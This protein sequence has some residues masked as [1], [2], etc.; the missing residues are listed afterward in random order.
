L[1][2]RSSSDGVIK[3]DEPHQRN[4]SMGSV[5]TFWMRERRSS[6]FVVNSRNTCKSTLSTKLGHRV[7]SIRRVVKEGGRAIGSF[8]GAPLSF[9]IQYKS[10]RVDKFG[11]SSRMRQSRFFGAM[12]ESV[13]DLSSF[14]R[15][16]PL[17]C[18]R[19]KASVARE[20]SIG[21]WRTLA[22]FTNNARA[23]AAGA[24]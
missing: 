15:Q 1:G 16:T 7:P 12:C 10:S 19:I 6:W 18:K 2:I 17:R 20:L 24:F 11:S 23:S 21:F 4:D 13:R 5:S 9:D 8:I 14:I 3:W 22:F